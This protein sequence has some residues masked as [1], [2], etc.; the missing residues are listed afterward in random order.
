VRL[1]ADNDG[2]ATILGLWLALSPF[3]V[4]GCLK[5]RHALSVVGLMVLFG[6]PAI[7]AAV[8]LARTDSWWARR[9]YA[10]DKMAKAAHRYAGRS[11]ISDALTL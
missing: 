3:S 10:D 4:I 5:G 8:R 2:M 9:Y 6:V 7:L 11:T 1:L